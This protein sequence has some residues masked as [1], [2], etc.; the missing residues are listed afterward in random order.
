MH[1]Q[2]T[3]QKY[4]GYS[5]AA[6]FLAALYLANDCN[7]YTALHKAR[8]EDGTIRADDVK[9]IFLRHGLR[10]DSWACQ[11]DKTRTPKV[12]WAEV[13]EDFATENA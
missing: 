11:Y 3:E 9:S 12:N 5:N 13:A 8:Q 10:V 2:H 4:Q 7:A 6:T 1:T